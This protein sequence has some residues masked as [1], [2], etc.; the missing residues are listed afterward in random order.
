MNEVKKL[1]SS[2][3]VEL[4]HQVLNIFEC[5]AASIIVKRN[6]AAVCAAQYAATTT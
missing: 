4:E 5:D 2:S 1:P 6:F 3:K